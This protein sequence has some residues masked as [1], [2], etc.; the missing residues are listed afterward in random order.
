ML[1][2]LADVVV[3]VSLPGVGV[4][5]EVV[6][7]SQDSNEVAA[8]AVDAFLVP[9]HAVS[10]MLGLQIIADELDRVGWETEGLLLSGA[11]AGRELDSEW[12][13]NKINETDIGKNVGRVPGQL[14]EAV[15]F[16]SI[17]VIG[18]HS[19]RLHEA[20]S[21]WCADDE[22]A[23]WPIAEPDSR[24]GAGNQKSDTSSL[25]RAKSTLLTGIPEWSQTWCFLC[26]LAE[27]QLP[28][29]EWAAE[30][31][32]SLTGSRTGRLDQGRRVGCW[33]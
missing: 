20:G 11:I 1:V 29:R 27:E 9:W 23:E 18:V 8:G 15:V 24:G 12:E 31:Q 2:Y 33:R 32:M 3:E 6:D 4:L 25:H 28:S 19:S 5:G 21:I 26:R 13:T 14:G 10:G 7:W 17:G 22:E 16:A 30:H